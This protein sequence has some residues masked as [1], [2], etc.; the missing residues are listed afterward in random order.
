MYEKPE[1]NFV[2]NAQDVILGF[3]LLG[4]DLDGTWMPGG[5]NFLPDEESASESGE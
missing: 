4:G 1:V 5:M 3:A 2:G